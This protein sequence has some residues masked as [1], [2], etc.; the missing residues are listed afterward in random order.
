MND[1]YIEKKYLFDTWVVI[2]DAK[3]CMKVV[4]LL[5]INTSI[6][7]SLKV[8]VCVCNPLTLRKA[9]KTLILQGQLITKQKFVD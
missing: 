5:Y 7:N 1:I 2:Q 8:S 9:D 4:I 6:Y 3:A